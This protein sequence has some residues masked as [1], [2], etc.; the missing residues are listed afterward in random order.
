MT[1]RGKVK[2]QYEKLKATFDGCSYS[3]DFNF[4]STCCDAHDFYYATGRVS[5]WEA[6]A[7]LFR[8]IK[9]AGHPIVAGVYWLA[10]ASV[11]WI[12]WIKARRVAKR[13]RVNERPDISS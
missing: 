3:P 7:R 1:F 2:E 4:G 11:G 6:D 12:P 13:G 8:C 9:K 10:V 5:K